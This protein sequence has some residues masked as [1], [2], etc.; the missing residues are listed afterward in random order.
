MKTFFNPVILLCFSLFA[1]S[2]HAHSLW[3]EKDSSGTVGVCFGE[4]GEGLREKTGGKLDN[5]N[6]EAWTIGA[7]GKKIPATVKRA[8][9]RIVIENAQGNAIAQDVNRPIRVRKPEE[10]K[11]GGEYSGGTNRSF[12]YTR[13]AENTSA[14]QKP[15]MKLDVVPAAQDSIQVYFDG[16]PL[17]EAKVSVIAPNGWIKEF[18]ADS[19]GVVKLEMPWR[20]LYVIDVTQMVD[21]PGEFQGQAYEAER[22]HAAF[23]TQ[24]A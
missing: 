19:Q 18:K 14:A 21:K 12:L 20:G 22:H 2:A 10:M 7:D 9:D 24:K 8:E 13:F 3:M 1:P 16:K 6:V 15:E 23:S 11:N 5:I 17:G 4:Y